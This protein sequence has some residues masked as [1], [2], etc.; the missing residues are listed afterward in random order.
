MCVFGEPVL[1]TWRQEEDG[2]D[3]KGNEA[4]QNPDKHLN[5]VAHGATVK[6]QLPAV[7]EC[8]FGNP[9]LEKHRVPSHQYAQCEQ[10]EECDWN[11]Q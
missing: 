3:A 1:A 10:A 2:I 11:G 4:E 8:V 6:A 9:T 7:D 5:P